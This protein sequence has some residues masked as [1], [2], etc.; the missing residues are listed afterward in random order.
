MKTKKLFGLLVGT[1]CLFSGAS[2]FAQDAQ[3]IDSLFFRGVAAFEIGNYDDALQ[4]FE[5]LD[6]VYPGHRRLTASLLMQGKSLYED[7]EYQ[8]ALESYRELMDDFPKSEYADDARYGLATCYYRQGNTLVAVKE[9][10]LVLEQSQDVRLVRNAA[11][12]SSELMD[13]RLRLDELQALLDDVQGEKAEAAV[14]VRIAQR[15]MDRQHYQASKKVI[16]DYLIRYPQSA[17]VFQMEELLSRADRLGR[18]MIKIGVIL[19][20]SGSL[21]EPG[22]ALLT[23]I[24]YAAN[25]HNEKNQEK[26]E[27]IIRDS[28]G[29]IL[30][31]I[32]AA[33]ELCQDS[34]V[35]AIIGELGS[36]ITAA[37]GGVAQAHEVT[38]LSPVAAE[39]GLTS[40]GD[41]VFQLNAS[42][43][44]RAR[45]LAEY[46]VDGLG[47]RRFAFLG[48]GDNYGKIMYDNFKQSVQSYGADLLVEKW[49]FPG[50]NDFGEQFKGIREVG[51]TRMLQDSVLK[52]VSEEELETMIEQPFVQLEDKSIEELVDST[53]FAVTAF[54]GLFIPAYSEELERLIPQFAFYNISAQLLGGV[55]WHDATLL[56]NEKNAEYAN[57]AIF[58][59]DF[60]ISP[61]NFRYMR[62]RNEYRK[63]I[64]TTPGKMD[65]FGYDATTILLHLVTEGARKRKEL[66]I[67]LAGIKDFPGIRG[68]ITF[69]ADRVNPEITLLQYRG[70]Q[71]LKI[72]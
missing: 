52:I 13:K 36:D 63:Q 15:E 41:Y 54:E 53:D 3:A 67:G 30:N 45:V 65:V 20:L 12:L 55:T 14:V 2:L 5:F 66:R 10:M 48:I 43:D 23:G 1:I 4:T 8:R 9:L 60:Y 69:N 71:V 37:I 64:G 11:K 46:A 70:G 44:I 27:L 72:R 51:I 34:E 7:H 19:P 38:L 26:I 31:A 25:Q 56:D 61:N 24:E 42:M 62:F 35:I 29:R 33:Q 59:S 68:E 39:G 58:V 32:K 6:R 22:N 57:N 21:S 50:A 18:G 49:Y 40:I 47:L 16:Q 17:H 28:A